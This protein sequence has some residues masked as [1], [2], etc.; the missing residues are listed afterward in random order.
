MIAAVLCTILPP[1][2]TQIGEYLRARA[3]RAHD[4]RLVALEARIAVL[5][6]QARGN[7]RQ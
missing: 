7:T 6:A 1:L 2:I 5:E 4:K 3:A